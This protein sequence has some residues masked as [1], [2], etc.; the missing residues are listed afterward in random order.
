MKLRWVG[1]IVALILL[2][3]V[4]EATRDAKHAEIMRLGAVST[5]A[6]GISRYPR[7]DVCLVIFFVI[8]FEPFGLGKWL[9]LFIYAPVLAVVVRREISA[10]LVLV[11]FL[12]AAQPLVLVPWLSH[13]ATHALVAEILLAA[14]GAIWMLGACVP[15]GLLLR[16]FGMFASP[17]SAVWIL[18]A[19]WGRC[20]L[21][22]F[23]M[24]YL[25]SAHAVAGNMLVAQLASV[26]GVLGLGGGVL[27][28]CSTTA[29]IA[30]TQGRRFAA[31]TSVVL[32]VTTGLAGWILMPPEGEGR[33]EFTLTVACLTG[34]GATGSE[35]GA[36]LIEQFEHALAMPDIDLIVF[37]E[38]ALTAGGR[39]NSAY[40]DPEELGQ[41]LRLRKD[42]PMVLAGAYETILG[43][44]GGLDGWR[45]PLIVLNGAKMSEVGEKQ[46]FAPVAER[47]PFDG[48]PILSDLGKF[49]SSNPTQPIVS[50]SGC[51]FRTAE[52]SI[53]ACQCLEAM[54]P[55]LWDRKSLA[56]K[57]QIQ[58]AIANVRAY[59]SSR[60]QELQ[61]RAARIL[62]AIEYRAPFIYV[63]FDRVDWVDE[64]GRVHHVELNSSGVGVVRIAVPHAR[65]A[66][67]QEEPA[68]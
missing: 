39:A 50:S 61:S 5:L 62:K 16:R 66:T 43:E 32:V 36:C 21:P 46:W 68:S 17:L 9:G 13:A 51:S 40:V 33:Q 64:R 28:I 24:P 58:L 60:T 25:L 34:F 19:E 49:L 7:T 27:L 14:L 42:P 11:A 63:S 22:S 55:D 8:Q 35:R 38:S 57:P 2:L 20:H 37:P 1:V 4:L 29:L 30:R 3:I 52:V 54:M 59:R 18:L 48:I 47:R 26:V 65:E 12:G 44:D 56:E 53:A 15:A 67:R 41:L 23:P 31:T 6:F 45:K 10:T